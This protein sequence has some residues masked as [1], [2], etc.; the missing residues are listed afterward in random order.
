MKSL[1][2]SV[3]L[4]VDDVEENLTLMKVMLSPLNLE[5]IT[6]VSGKEALEKI[7]GVDLA[8]AL[9][10]IQMPEM[11]GIE[12]AIRIT[13]DKNRTKVPIIF[14]TAHFDDKNLL[15]Q[16]YEAGGV[17]YIVKPFE[18]EIL[19][20]KVRV[21]LEL[22]NQKH[23]LIESRNHL[24]QLTNELKNIF[25]LSLD[26][27]CV[28]DIHQFTFKKVN[29]AFTR[30]LGY[31]TE[32][33]VGKKVLD[34]VHPD[35]I[36]DTLAIL[37]K[38]SKG[39]DIIN[40]EVRGRCKNGSYK[41]LSW[42][43]N[44]ILKV[45]LAYS[46]AHD[47]TQRKLHEEKIRASE[48][49]YRTLLNAS[50]EGIIIMDLEGWV[51]EVSD[52]TLEL[53]EANNKIEFNETSLY[54]L[55][56]EGEELKLRK[57]LEKTIEEGLVQDV[58]FILLTKKKSQLYAEISTT[59]IQE[60]NGKPIAFMAIIRDISKRKLLEQK[61]LQ[62]ERLAGI[63]E[64]ATSIAHE[65]N[66]PLNNISFSLE[67]VLLEI[68]NNKVVDEQYLQKKTFNIFEN[69]HRME[70]IIDHVRA[71]SRGL[72]DSFQGVFY[73]NECIPNA[74]MLVSEQFINHGIKITSN[75]ENTNP[76]I[77]G[78]SYKLE[79]V[80][81]NLLINA[82]DAL[83]EKAKTSGVKFNKALIINTYSQNQS[84]IIEVKDN[85]CGISKKD[86]DKILLPFYSTK[87]AGRGTGLGL[88]ISDSIIKEMKG[89]IS[90]SSEPGEGTCVMIS[91]PTH[92]ML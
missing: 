33:I 74:V 21:F 91:L 76:A 60:Q 53:F 26:M 75:L 37:E 42:V 73:I 48:Q 31:P 92:S 3:V 2:Q 61:L 36:Q 28:I 17:D 47:I 58:E 64:M 43:S 30:I 50:P 8:L 77:L 24:E 56:S 22:D 59:L 34:Y 6:A 78:N 82:K 85:G 71:F 14:I 15:R 83:E 80:I 79:Q 54:N 25:D 67:N 10:D 41:W 11:N 89:S 81:I 7:E 63:G 51:T 44:P 49:M 55:I 69:I 12:L 35:D 45:G 86:L 52:I 32:S 19:K 38:G 29:R 90:I 88:S 1:T 5:V 66:Q 9:I 40:F 72:D 57:V 4:I 23:L 65:I 70:H 84:L 39:I 18:V 13:N 87:Q 20:G 46:I 68:R 62:S 27:V 16:C